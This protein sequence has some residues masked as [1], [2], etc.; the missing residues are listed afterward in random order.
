MICIFWIMKKILHRMYK[1]N[2][3]IPLIIFYIATFTHGSLDPKSVY[4]SCTVSY[5]YETIFFCTFYVYFLVA[6]RYLC[7]R[8]VIRKAI[9]RIS[10]LEIWN[11]ACF[12]KNWGKVLWIFQI[13]SIRHITNTFPYDMPTTLMCNGLITYYFATGK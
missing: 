2:I 5:F 4:I 6:F 11:F 13:S 12:E 10:K 1:P 7:G 9:W 8:H 3:H